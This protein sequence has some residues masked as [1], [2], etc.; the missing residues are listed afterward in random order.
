MSADP[1]PEIRTRLAAWQ[2]REFNGSLADGF[3]RAAAWS[4]NAEVDIVVLLREVEVLRNTA[5]G[6]QDRC[7]ERDG[8]IEELKDEAYVLRRRLLVL[9]NTTL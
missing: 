8:R 1:T 4:L 7:E 3:D 5:M 9:E 2:A 6:W